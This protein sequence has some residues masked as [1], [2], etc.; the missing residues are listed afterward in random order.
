[1]LNIWKTSFTVR[2]VRHWNRLI[3]EVVHGPVP[4]DFHGKAG[5]GSEQPDV[6]EDVTVHCRGVGLDNL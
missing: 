6:A 5:P 4:E 2:A 3:R 1:L